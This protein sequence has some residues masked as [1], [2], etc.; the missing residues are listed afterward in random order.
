MWR[1][2]GGEEEENKTE[3]KEDRKGNEKNGEGDRR[4]RS[5]R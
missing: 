4:E 1:K 5:V 2:K 3:N